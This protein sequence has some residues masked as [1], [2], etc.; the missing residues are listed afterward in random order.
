[1]PDARGYLLP[2]ERRILLRRYAPVLVLFPEDPTRA[3]Y[4]DDGDAIYTMRGSYH[5]R[6][7]TL[8]LRAARVRYRRRLLIRSPGLWFRS[9][10]Y[11]AEKD[12]A[13]AAI[14]EKNLVAALDAFCDDP[15]YAGLNDRERKA[16]IRNRLV[17]QQLAARIR[18]FDL[19]FFHAH[20]LRHWRAYFKLLRQA[21]PEEKRSVVYGRVVQGLAPLPGGKTSSETRLAEAWSYGPHDVS[22]NRVALQYWFSYYYDDWANRHEG[23]WEMITLL[24]ELD[25]D[26]LRAK[27]DLDENRLLVGA[28]VHDAG[29]ASHEEGHRRRWVDVQKT[30]DGRPLVY[31]ARGSSASYFQWQRD[32][33]A[34]SARVGIV[35]KLL[36]LPG[37]LVR[38]RRLFGRRWDAQYRARFIGEDP[39][40]TDWVAADPQ[41]IDRQA[42]SPGNDL[43]RALLKICQGVR[44]SPRFAPDAGQD[45]ASYHLETEDLFWLEMVQEYGVQWGEDAWL[46]GSRGPAGISRAR[47]EKTRRSIRQMAQLEARIERALSQLSRTRFTAANAIPELGPI[48]VPLRPGNLRR[49]GCFPA[50][51]RSQVYTMWAWILKDHPEAWPGGPGILLRWVLAQHL[52]PAFLWIF[53]REPPAEPLL[54]RAD[55]MYHIKTLLAQVRRKRYEAQH[56]GSKWDNPFAWVR[57]VCRADTFFYGK[58]QHAPAQVDL[59]YLECRDAEMSLE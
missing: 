57:H 36:S 55:P 19:P 24:L 56:P 33:Y 18:G 5:P 42:G 46:P 20:N 34:A 28:Q 22:R 27:G 23:D 10:S 16:A 8:F 59:T 21:A 25:P 38:G 39:K 54:D 49:G 7:V 15:R 2:G 31:V 43:E 37:F 41:P 30:R 11:H 9:R 17:Q 32:G 48:L 26:L 3:P 53:R 44:R 58:T 29:Y 51:V 50:T 35:E 13:E 47:R 45:D 6:S 12:V 52:R 4:P 40:T 1:M 14:T